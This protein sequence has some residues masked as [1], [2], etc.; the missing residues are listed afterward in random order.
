MVYRPAASDAE[1]IA[2]TREL[3][4]RSREILAISYQASSWTRPTQPAVTPSTL[5]AGPAARD[6]REMSASTFLCP[7]ANVAVQH[8]IDNGATSSDDAYEAIA[9]PACARLHF[10][11]RKTGKLL[12]HER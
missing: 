10:V 3:V 12:G 8:W 1:I 11:N 4:R 6:G 5:V 7:K 2:H 9:C